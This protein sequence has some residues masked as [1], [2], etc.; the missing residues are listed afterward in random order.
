MPDR[1]FTLDEAREHVPWL[2]QLFSDLKPLRA[3]A[4]ELSGETRALELRIGSTGGRTT[5]GTCASTRSRGW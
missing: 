4:Q 5:R 2:A 1:Y 3:R